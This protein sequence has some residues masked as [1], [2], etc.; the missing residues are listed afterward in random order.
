MSE[1]LQFEWSALEEL[2]PL[3]ADFVKQKHEGADVDLREAVD[4]IGRALGIEDVDAFAVDKF[5]TAM[6]DGLGLV[7]SGE[8]AAAIAALFVKNS[9]PVME[10]VVQFATG[11]SDAVTLVRALNK[12]CFG[13]TEML[14]SI[15]QHA[16][17]ISDQAAGSLANAY[18]PYLV[19]IYCFTAAFKI[20]QRAAKD[21]KLARERRMEAERLSQEAIALIKTEREEMNNLLSNYLLA[22]LLPFDE[23]VAAM[24][25]AV[26]DDDDDGF[27]RANAGLW[28]VFGRESQYSSAAEFED[29]MLSDEAFKL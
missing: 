26:L 17:G 7:M 16:L 13:D 14:Q 3:C 28:E 19:S 24:D 4:A 6:K 9:K 5:N 10:L 23:G 29:L 18:G 15:L 11:G 8:D 22:R 27:I 20:Y 1:S 12:V 25:R 2:L 21:A